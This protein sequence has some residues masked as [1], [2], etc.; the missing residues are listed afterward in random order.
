MLINLRN[1]LMTGKRLPYDAEVEY[2]EST[3]TQWI[4]TGIVAADDVGVKMHVV[5]AEKPYSTRLFFWRFRYRQSL[6]IRNQPNR[7]FR[8][9]ELSNSIQRAF[10]KFAK[11]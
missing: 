4:D 10:S 11:C 8:V 5:G 9:V 1:A 3:G 7:T 2:L 6:W